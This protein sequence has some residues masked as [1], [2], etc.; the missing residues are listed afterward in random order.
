MSATPIKRGYK[1][2]TRA[3]VSDYVCQFH[4]YPVKRDNTEKQQGTRIIKD[5]TLAFVDGDHHMYFD[6][7]LQVFNVLQRS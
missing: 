2:W 5:H 4:I 7:F 1:C 3:D 6:H